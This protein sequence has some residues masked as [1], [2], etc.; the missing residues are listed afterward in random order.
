MKI[1]PFSQLIQY[2]ILYLVMSQFDLPLNIHAGI[3]VPAGCG[4]GQCYF[5][6][7]D[8]HYYHYGCDG[9]DDRVS[10]SV[11]ELVFLATALDILKCKCLSFLQE[12]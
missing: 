9:Q 11:A 6:H 7:G 2:W 5:V 12:S 8:Y 3:D 4:D 10:R 1:I